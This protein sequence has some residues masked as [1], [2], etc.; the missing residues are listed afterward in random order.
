M[1]KE[2]LTKLVIFVLL[3]ILLL[4]VA[5]FN[6]ATN[7]EVVV[8]VRS[9]KLVYAPSS[10]AIINLTLLSSSSSDNFY[11]ETYVNQKSLTS[12]NLRIEN[13]KGIKLLNVSL[14]NKEGEVVVSFVVKNFMF[15]VKRKDVKIL[16]AD[17]KDRK[18]LILLLVWHEHQAPNVLPDGKYFGEWAFYH[19]FSNELAPTFNGGPYMYH[20]YE[21]IEHKGIKVIEHL[22][23]SLLYQWNSSLVNG[24][25]LENGVYVPPNSSELEKVR[26][27]LNTF[28]LLAKEG[29]V[30][31]LTSVFAHTIT[32]F[33]L[34]NYNMSDVIN[35]E[36]KIGKTVTESIIGV[37]P[38]G[39]WTP[40]MAFSMKNVNVYNSNNLYYTFLD[41]KYHFLGSRGNKS[42]I[43]EPY[44]LKDE[45]GKQIVVFFR[46]QEVSD[47]I[48]F[49]NNF[50][51]K[52]DADSFARNLVIKILEKAWLSNETYTSYRVFIIALDGENWMIFS[53]TPSNAALFLDYFYGY[54]E[55][56]QE[57][58]VLM[59]CTAKEALTFLK[60]TRVLYFIPTNSWLGSFDKWTTEKAQTSQWK[61]VELLYKK[62]EAY[63]QVH[64]EDDN[65]KRAMFA[66]Y[67]ALDS[68]YWWAEFYSPQV[69]SSWLSYAQSCLSET[70]G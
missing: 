51:S 45:D 26:W 7:K 8:Y 4:F 13:Y 65:F 9:D 50:L 55:Q 59:T 52:E 29:R 39:V 62:L 11:V 67:N 68:D 1:D 24:Y 40:E 70:K 56:A 27:T 20:A 42:S 28:K 57:D 33:L 66:F 21:L 19:T 69:I 31:V 43:Y 53:K 35:N 37:V 60:P 46:D 5:T 16:V 30:E 18:P 54:L 17:S 12:F 61:Q 10:L 44:I 23:P 14:P 63:K 64:G 47:Q 36:L 25:T 3:L 49:Q 58:K 38:T 41:S 34:D 48:G 15:I 2:S 6:L 22:S 32:G